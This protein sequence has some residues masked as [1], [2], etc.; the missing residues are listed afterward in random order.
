MAETPDQDKPPFLRSPAG[1]ALLVFGGAA[2]FFLV[3]EHR[4]HLYGILP[5]LILAICP[6]MHFF[7]HRGHGGHGSDSANRSDSHA[8][9]PPGDER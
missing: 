5:F 3:A 1:I 8:G 2:G 4:A 7:M 9:H 6:L